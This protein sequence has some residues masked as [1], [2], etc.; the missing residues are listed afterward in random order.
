MPWKQ[1]LRWFH[2]LAGR[3]SGL[4]IRPAVRA[5][6]V[7]PD[8]RTLMIRYANEYDTWWI[9]PGGGIDPGESDIEALT[10]ELREEVGLTEF[11]VGPLL[12]EREHY[13]PIETSYG[14]QRNRFYRVR[15]PHFEV[16]HLGEGTEARW[17]SVDE[18]R[19]LP[20]PPYDIEELLS[21]ASDW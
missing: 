8:G 21:S 12:F 16:E 20:D 3:S 2:E 10:R 4:P 19:A 1:R 13:F 6:V 5:V 18:L 9:S 7:D 11:E 15:V 17:F 14:G